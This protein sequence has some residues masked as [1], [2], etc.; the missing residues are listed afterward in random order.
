MIRHSMGGR[1]TSNTVV[2]QLETGKRF[3]FIASSD[4]HL[5]YPGAYG[6]GVLGV[7]ADDL[8]SE[9]LFEAIRARR[10]YAAT[11]DRITLEVAMNG[12]PMGS[13]V[14]ATADRE[15]DI[16]VEGD[17]AVA[18]V[19]LIR[20]GKTIERYFPEDHLT[21]PPQLPG[22]VKCRF[23]YGWGPWAD[24]NLGRTCLWDMSL[25]LENGE[26]RRAMPY[27]QSAP[28]NERLRDQLRVISPQELR[29]KSNTTRVKGY[30]E[31][32]TKSVVCEIEGRPDSVL[33]LKLREPVEQTVSAR[34]KDLVD[35]NVVTFTGAFT[36]ES[37]II[38]RLV[39]PSEY[40]MKIRWSDPRKISQSA[41]WYYVRV[42][43]HNGHLAWSSPIWVG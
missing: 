36:T 37:Y 19:E 12:Q 20:N 41:D 2:P 13:E 24:L 40:S 43:Q 10:T 1:S 5:G 4:D 7:W 17:D 22:K 18:M 9:S 3:G 26:F 42:T 28:F 39:G 33:T 35:D 38:N 21:G 27:F 15:F 34:L 6:E 11:G 16:R 31:D 30:G 29:L 14:P 8:S 25:H 32:P 23:Q